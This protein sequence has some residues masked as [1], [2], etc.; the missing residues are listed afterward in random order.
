MRL[1]N[2]LVYLCS[3]TAC[4]PLS[5]LRTRGWRWWSRCNGV[6]GTSRESLWLWSS[7]SWFSARYQLMRRR[8]T[9]MMV[10][11]LPSSSTMSQKWPPK[12][13]VEHIAP[14]GLLHSIQEKV[15][16]CVGPFF[17]NSCHSKLSKYV[18]ARCFNIFRGRWGLPLLLIFSQIDIGSCIYIGEEFLQREVLS[19]SQ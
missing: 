18:G 10:R 9:V 17:P 7:V 13:S 8:L 5:G 14:L 12:P 6:W 2:P 1:R 3:W 11:L 16:L 4:M 19:A 15:Y